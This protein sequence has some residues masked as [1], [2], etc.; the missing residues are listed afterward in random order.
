MKIG[1]VKN[2]LEKEFE[3]KKETVEVDEISKENRIVEDM[4]FKN[5]I[6]FL[7]N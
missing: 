7:G 2:I 3:D 1:S 4:I 6:N 5:I